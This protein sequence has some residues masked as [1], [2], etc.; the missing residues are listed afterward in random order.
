ML[1]VGWVSFF[2]VPFFLLFVIF[3]LGCAA[4]NESPGLGF[5]WWQLC[6][7][8]WSQYIWSPLEKK[9]VFAWASL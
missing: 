2:L 9:I 4:V 8:E 3:Y 5:C 1:C 6:S 7:V